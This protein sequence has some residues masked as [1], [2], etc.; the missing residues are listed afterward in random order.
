MEYFNNQT[1]SNKHAMIMLKQNLL[2]LWYPSISYLHIQL[3]KTVVLITAKMIF[4]NYFC[5]YQEIRVETSIGQAP[6]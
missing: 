4:S 2:K 1:L 3:R 5:F 6:F